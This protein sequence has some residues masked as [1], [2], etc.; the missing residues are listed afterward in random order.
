MKVLGMFDK[1]YL[2][3]ISENA[4]MELV[5]ATMESYAVQDDNKK[6]SANGA[7]YSETYG[8]IWGSEVDL[9]DDLVLFN[10]DNVTLDAMTL[11]SGASVLPSS[12]LEI[13]RD[14]VNYF[15]PH[16]ELL[17]DFHT[18]PFTD[19]LDVTAEL[20]RLS[21]TD[22]KKIEENQIL[23]PDIRVSL[24]ITT[25]PLKKRGELRKQ[26]TDSTIVW[27]MGDF[28]FWLTAYVIV[29]VYRLPTLQVPDSDGQNIPVGYSVFPKEGGWSVF[30]GQSVPAIDD[31]ASYNHPLV[32]LD[33]P[34]LFGFQEITEF[35]L[36]DDSS[37]P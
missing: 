5:L 1:D 28:R 3:R 18:H 24:I 9:D 12:G 32:M 10:V 35:G 16:I 15:W 23:D 25:A 17:G 29:P 11:R 26:L 7:K 34:F 13:K 6:K 27:T 37:L 19:Y 4:L 36:R 2:V 14:A 20:F 8:L 33:V 22:R 31:K 30:Q 21:E